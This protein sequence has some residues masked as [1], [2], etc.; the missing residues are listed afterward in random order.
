MSEPFASENMSGL[1][2]LLIAISRSEPDITYFF[3]GHALGDGR[4]LTITNDQ[5]RQ[6]TLLADPHGP[7]ESFDPRNLPFLVVPEIY[8]SIAF[9]RGEADRCLVVFLEDRIEGALGFRDALFGLA[10]DALGRPLLMMGDPDE[11]E[12]CG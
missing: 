3:C 5:N 4:S 11:T 1:R 9:I 10:E 7:F 6:I 12:W 2:I 8:S